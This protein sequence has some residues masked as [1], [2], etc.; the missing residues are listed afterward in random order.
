V[1]ADERQRFCYADGTF[2][3]RNSGCIAAPDVS[4]K[5]VDEFPDPGGSCDQ[6]MRE[7]PLVRTARWVLL[8]V[9]TVAL[10]AFTKHGSGGLLGGA[11][12]AK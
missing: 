11:A 4:I 1:V 10:I 3:I 6:F 7:N 2:D 5:I 8:I 12:I 9:L